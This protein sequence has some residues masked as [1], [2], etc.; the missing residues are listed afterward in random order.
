MREGDPYDGGGERDLGSHDGSGKAKASTVVI[1][2]D[3]AEHAHDCSG[4]H[5]VTDTVDSTAERS[6]DQAAGRTIAA[7][8]RAFDGRSVLHRDVG[9]DGAA[10][11]RRRRGYLEGGCAWMPWAT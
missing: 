3:A 9:V 7:H 2:V 6:P 4:R 11:G 10:L 5:A 1:G 8:G